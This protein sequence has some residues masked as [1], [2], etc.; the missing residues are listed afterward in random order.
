MVKS[1]LSNRKQFVYNKESSSQII[2][3]ITCGV[4]QGSILGPLLFLLYINDLYKASTLTTVNFADDTNLVQL[5]ENIEILFNNM[6]NELKRIS[7]WF[8]KNKLS[9]NTDKTKFILFHPTS[10]K[11]RIQN[12]L[13]DLFI[14]NTIIKREKFTKFLGVII[15]ENLSWSQQIDSISMK[16]AK[17][18]GVLYKARYILNKKQLT[19]LYY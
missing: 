15:D 16:V 18:I 11:K 19:Q 7:Y 14:D 13:P 8:R 12:I 10:K 3:N 17:N 9:L 4:P 5:H 6:N 1:Y 2:K